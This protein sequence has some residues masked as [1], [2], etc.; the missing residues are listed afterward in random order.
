M[1]KKKRFDLGVL[2][3]RF[4]GV[5]SGHEMM[6]DTALAICGEV[7]I[8]IG[9][10]QESGTAKN[11]FTYEIRREMLRRIY[12]DK[13]KIFPLP[14]IGVGNC[15]EWGEYVA[16]EAKECF[17]RLPDVAVSGKEERRASWLEG[18]SGA[19]IAELYIPK[20]V[21]MSATR[22]REFFFEDDV[23]SWKKFTNPALWDMYEELRDAVVKSAGVTETDS[24]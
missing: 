18:P 10:S 15:A 13:V 5:H 19:S 1:K 17:G 16:R 8:F 12:G 11:P 7:G 3:G 2:V 22:M 9:S 4:Q 23:E 21:E 20:T 24:I 6:I 14:D